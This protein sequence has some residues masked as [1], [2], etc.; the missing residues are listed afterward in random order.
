M[1]TTTLISKVIPVHLDARLSGTVIIYNVNIPQLHTWIRHSNL[2][3]IPS[4][5]YLNQ[6]DY[7]HAIRYRC[8][9]QQHSP[10]RNVPVPLLLQRVQ[11]AACSSV[12]QPG[13][14]RQHNQPNHEDLWPLLES[15]P[16]ILELEDLIPIAESSCTSRKTLIVLCCWEGAPEISGSDWVESSWSIIQEQK[17]FVLGRSYRGHSPHFG[18][19]RPRCYELQESSLGGDWYILPCNQVPD[20]QQM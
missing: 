9:P 1:W 4:S 20:T 11:Y 6:H 17:E 14:T 10:A 8:H 7:L 15:P 5:K 19:T 3:N 2:I 18:Y 16:R 13:W 12:W